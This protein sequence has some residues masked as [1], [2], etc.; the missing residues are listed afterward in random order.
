MPSLE[1]YFQTQG[2]SFAVYHQWLN[3]ATPEELLADGVGVGMLFDLYG[4]GGENISK[5]ISKAENYLCN[6]GFTLES[7][8]LHS[9]TYSFER[10]KALTLLLA[11]YSS[12]SMMLLD[13]S[14]STSGLELAKGASEAASGIIGFI[15][16]EEI[17]SRLLVDD[18]S[19]IK[20]EIKNYIMTS[21]GFRDIP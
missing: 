19:G 21:E 13:G 4:R 14:P 11:D 3:K 17:S 7:T 5:Y 12:V 16:E 9:W 20:Y 18:M 6:N 15:Q 8:R 10:N 1:S 2:K